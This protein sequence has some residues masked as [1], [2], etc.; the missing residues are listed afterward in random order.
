MHPEGSNACSCQIEGACESGR[1][2]RLD[3]A[4]PAAFHGSAGHATEYH[5]G[6]DALVSFGGYTLNGGISRVRMFT[7][8]NST[9][10]FLDSPSSLPTPVCSR[11]LSEQRK[12]G[13]EVER[14]RERSR[15]TT[16][17][18]THTPAENRH[19]HARARARGDR[20]LLARSYRMRTPATAKRRC[21]GVA[22]GKG[23]AVGAV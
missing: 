17:R 13:R 10:S 12:G 6:R 21:A 15:E 9:W 3:A 20:S 18:H 23:G 19:T 8:A 4:E 11:L 5:T 22:R 2:R 14:G 16:H 7:F 1:W